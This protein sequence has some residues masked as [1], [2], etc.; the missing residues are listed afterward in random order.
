VT[1][2]AA[3][4]TADASSDP[5]GGATA[6]GVDDAR[7]WIL[8]QIGR[9]AT[10]TRPLAECLGLVLADDAVAPDASPR[11]DTAAMDG[12][13]LHSQPNATSTW[14]ALGQSLAGTS[15]DGTLGPG[16]AIL[17][18]TGAQVPPG[19]GAVVPLEAAVERDGVV[20]SGISVTPGAN[21]RL[22]GSDHDAGDVVVAAG[23]RLN[24]A[25]VAVLGSMGHARPQVVRRPR[26]GVMSTGDEVVGTGSSSIRDANRPGLLALVQA[27]GALPVDLGV[28]RDDPVDL[29]RRVERAVDECD[30]VITTGG[31]S[32]G[33]H[34]HVKR[35]LAD[36]ASVTGTARWMRVAVRPA[37]PLMFAAIGGVPVFG[38]PGNPASAFVSYHL[39]ARPALDRLAGDRLA[40][41]R[42]S[43]TA[44]AATDLH[45]RP[46][47]RV[48]VAPVVAEVVAG[49]LCI[50]P[51]RGSGGHSLAATAEANAYAYLPDGP[52]VTAGTVV[53][54]GWT[55]A[56]T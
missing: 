20:R 51:V 17:I 13:A 47:G 40:A 53:E 56:G 33:D 32:V 27:D 44:V 49:R 28:A 12:Y 43:F 38:L 22:R 10:V 23:T 19:A 24:P 4:L 3:V 48:H 1:P 18:M 16:E 29:R 6:I 41:A 21:I 46:D 45:R 31:V 50:R 39:F 54:C 9:C 7:G 25:H 35:V 42:R 15:F 5:W 26:I 14:R 30:A 11:F 37:K 52:A 55:V 36:L 8:D 2:G 34:D